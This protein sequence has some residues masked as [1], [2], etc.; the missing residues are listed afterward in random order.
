MR[1]DTLILLALIIAAVLVIA[2]V[3][4]GRADASTSTV[5]DK[6][7][8]WNF[9]S[10]LCV[11]D[12]R[13]GNPFTLCYC[14]CDE[15]VQA[16]VTEKIVETEKVVETPTPPPQEE[17]VKCNAGRGNGSEGDPDCDPGNS[18]GHNNGGD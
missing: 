12:Y 16:I 5:P 17:K 13:D 8:A 3:P 1:R 15:C 10:L 6:V 9:D 4:L 2:F 11:T 14:P 7:A 18:A